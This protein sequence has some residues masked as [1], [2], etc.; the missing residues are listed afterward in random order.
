M[1]AK[2]TSGAGSFTDGTKWGGGVAP[3]SG[4]DTLTI[5]HAMTWAPSAGSA[6]TIGTGTGVA[7]TFGSAGSLTITGLG[8]FDLTLAGSTAGGKVSSREL[9]VNATNGAVTINLDATGA[10]AGFNMLVGNTYD[11]GTG[12]PTWNRG[13]WDLNGNATY[14]ITVQSLPS[15]G[16]KNSNFTGGTNGGWGHIDADYVTFRRIGTSSAAAFAPSMDTRNNN[17]T[18]NNVTL[19]ACGQITH[20]GNGSYTATLS[21]T[22]VKST[23]TATNGTTSWPLS[24]GMS[25]AG[26]RTFT[27]C[28]FDKKI[29][30]NTPLGFNGDACY[31]HN[32]WEGTNSTSVGGTLNNSFVRQTFDSVITSFNINNTFMYWDNPAGSNPH[33]ISVNGS[34]TGAV[35]Y[36][37]NGNIYYYNGNDAAGNVITTSSSNTTM[38]I[39]ANN[40]IVL[41]NAAGVS[42]GVLMT[43]NGSVGNGFSITCNHNTMY[44]SGIYGLE[45]GHLYSVGDTTNRYVAVKSN[46]FLG[47]TT[48]YKCLDIDAVLITDI[49]PPANA[50]YNGS[51]Q[52]K[53]TAGTAGFTNEG[54]GYAGKWSVTPGA[55]DIDGQD[56][57]FVDPNVSLSAWDLSLGGAGTDTAAA[58]RI[59]AN[60]ALAASLVSYI[61][62]GYAPRNAIYKNAGHD[63][64]TIGAVEFQASS[65]SWLALARRRLRR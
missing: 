35:N 47:G 65:G 12:S 51:Y 63:G 60:P 37:Y 2:T 6:F 50:N 32:G 45:I 59:Q 55:N 39:T 28:V 1:A 40:S 31:F 53:A 27:R 52:I 38:T 5:N 58:A 11:G 33:W 21:Y 3:V 49:I 61:R 46:L 14:G 42:S 25:A 44:V 17:H 23:N 26:T 16:T 43:S 54:K 24:Y 56:P 19:D 4:A 13:G 10:G 41:R 64:V 34:A 48:G 7:L 22:D 8:A 29:K 18:W 15:D 20:S 9:V 62:A 30:I 36:T 57:Q